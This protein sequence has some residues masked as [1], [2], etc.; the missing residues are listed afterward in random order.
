MLG[1][2]AEYAEGEIKT[3]GTEILDAEW[4]AADNLPNIPPKVSIARSL[5]DWFVESYGVAQ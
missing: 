4:F 5:I 1:F 2:I 3:D